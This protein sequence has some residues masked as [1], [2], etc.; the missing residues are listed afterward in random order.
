MEIS[1]EKFKRIVI[2]YYEFAFLFVLVSV[3]FLDKDISKY[4][5]FESIKDT[6]LLSGG[7][8]NNWIPK[9]FFSFSIIL[10]IDGFL[11]ER[12]KMFR[13]LLVS[14]VFSGATY[15]M[16]RTLSIPYIH[17]NLF[18]WT[19][20]LYVGFFMYK[21][22]SQKHF[23]QLLRCQDHYGSCYVQFMG[24]WDWIVEYS[25]ISILQICILYLTMCSL[26]RSFGV[27]A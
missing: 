23:S 20:I 18:G 19:L 4:L 1:C 8:G 22:N 2:P 16:T 26:L 14:I 6:L 9:L 11:A 12:V 13:V 15:L 25:Q 3:L 27:W 24:I 17:S 21:Y 10:L 7:V 5:G